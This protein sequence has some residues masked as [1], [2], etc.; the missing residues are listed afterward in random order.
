MADVKVVLNYAGVGELLHEVGRVYCGSLAQ[1]M[2]ASCGN[3]YESEIIRAGTRTIA[4]VRTTHREAIQDNLDN[5]TILRA[6][7][8]D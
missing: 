8:N 2:A 4:V 7:G 1:D 3:G 6:C 5:N